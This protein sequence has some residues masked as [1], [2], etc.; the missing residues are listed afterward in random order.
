MKSSTLLKKTSTKTLVCMNNSSE[1]KYFTGTICNNT[2]VVSEDTKSVLCWKCL[3]VKMGNP[4]PIKE[5]VKS[6]YPR[7]WQFMSLFVDKDGNVYEKGILNKELKGKYPP[8]E[9][10]QKTKEEEKTEAISLE[11]IKE[12]QKKIKV[13][14]NTTKLSKLKK[15]LSKMMKGMS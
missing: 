13:E 14:K 7:G 8:T 5:V 2:L 3:V 1:S 11:K 9:I 12:L 4:T 6:G 15:E 10:K